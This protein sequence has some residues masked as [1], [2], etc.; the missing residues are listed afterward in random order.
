MYFTTNYKKLLVLLFVFVLGIISTIAVN[1]MLSK[2]VDA[3]KEIPP[4]ERYWFVLY[5]KSNIEQLFKGVPGDYQ[6]SKLVKTFKVKTGMPGQRPTPLPQLMG[7]EYWVVTKKFKTKDIPET[8]PYFIELSV[9]V[10]DEYP[11]GPMPYEECNGQ[12]DWVL[13]GPFGLHGVNGDNERLSDMNPGSSGCIRHTD[14]DIA[15][16]YD[17]IN[18]EEEVRYYIQDI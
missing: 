1:A 9:P 3:P 16:L 14:E 5:R 4:K 11:Y 6:N 18:P 13:P 2:K 15:Y 8:A 12:C 7:E 17:I 10:T